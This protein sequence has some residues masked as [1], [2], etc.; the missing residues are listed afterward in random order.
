MCQ[1]TKNMIKIDLYSLN[2]DYIM[3]IYTYIINIPTHIL[4]LLILKRT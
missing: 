1:Y 4:R 3:F 2:K